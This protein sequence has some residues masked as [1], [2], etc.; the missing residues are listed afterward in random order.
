MLQH[1]HVATHPRRQRL[2]QPRRC[3]AHAVAALRNHMPPGVRHQGMAIDAALRA[4]LL[5]LP[6][7]SRS[8]DPALR[9]NRPRPQQNFPMVLAGLQGEVAGH[10]YRLG[11]RPPQRHVMLGEAHVVADG[12][13]EPHAPGLEQHQLLARP[14]QCAFAV[15]GAVRRHDVEQV[16]LAV[17]RD[18]L[19]GRVE[20]DRGVEQLLAAILDDA[21]AMHEDPVPPCQAAHQFIGRAACRTRRGQHLG[22]RAPAVAPAAQVGPGLRQRNQPRP[23][24][25]DG[26]ADQRLGAGQVGGLVAALVH[27][28]DAD[29]HQLAPSARPLALRIIKPR[30]R[31]PRQ[32]PGSPA[33]TAR[34]G[35]P[36]ARAPRCPGHTKAS[37]PSSPRTRSP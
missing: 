14:I 21:A 10:Q 5:I 31:A 7:G 13:A 8:D 35:G 29:A 22:C 26:S 18:L 20:H 15:A 12:A 37:Q 1:R 28:D 30:L 17:A 32:P 4:P 3:P 9:L 36:A 33:P 34:I 25:L 2:V 19:A 11:T 16:H 6:V 24:G 23:V 27:L